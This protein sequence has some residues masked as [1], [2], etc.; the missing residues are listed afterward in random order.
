MLSNDELLALCWQEGD[1]RGSLK[2]LV[3]QV[4][5]PSHANQSM[6]PP[7][8][9]SNPTPLLG[10]HE[11]GTVPAP[12][13]HSKSGSFSS[14]SSMGDAQN[15]GDSAHTGDS[16]SEASGRMGILHRTKATSRRANGASST[17]SNDDNRSPI[18][19]TRSPSQPTTPLL[20]SVLESETGEKD[21][22][23]KR[24]I[25]PERSDKRQSPLDSPIEE[26]DESTLRSSDVRRSGQAGMRPSSSHTALRT[27]LHSQHESEP[28]Q[29]SSQGSSAAFSSPTMSKTDLPE[30]RSS[31]KMTHQQSSTTAEERGNGIS[32][33]PK[34]LQPGGRDPRGIDAAD[35]AHMYLGGASSPLEGSAYNVHSP[36]N[37]REGGTQSQ[38]QQQQQAQAIH[39][40][41]SI[42]DMAR[43]SRAAMQSSMQEM[44]ALNREQPGQ[45][46]ATASA[47]SIIRQGSADANTGHRPQHPYGQHDPRDPRFSPTTGMVARPRTSTGSER[48]RAVSYAESPYQHSMHMMGR[49]ASSHANGVDA[50]RNVRPGMMASP[51]MARPMT[52]VSLRPLHQDHRSYGPAGQAN[53]R[54][55]HYMNEFGA[56]VPMSQPQGPH[57]HMQQQGFHPSDPRLISPPFAPPRPLTLHD[58]QRF[59]PLPPG[60]IRPLSQQHR[61]DPFINSQFPASNAR[62]VSEFQ[63]NPNSALQ[64]GMT[65][66]ETMTRQRQLVQAHSAQQLRGVDPRET[67][68]MSARPM[69]P[70]HPSPYQG[71][72]SAP[73]TRPPVQL[74]QIHYQ[75]HHHNQPTP[76][77][78]R[79][80]RQQPPPQSR[81]SNSKNPPNATPLTRP[82]TAALDQWEVP[83]N[84]RSSGSSFAT[85]SSSHKRNLSSEDRHSAGWI[86]EPYSA[87]TSARTSRSESMEKE[88]ESRLQVVNASESQASSPVTQSELPYSNYGAQEIQRRRSMP[89]EDD[90]SNLRPLPKLPPLSTAGVKADGAKSASATEG[91]KEDESNTIR[92]SEWKQMMIS[93][94]AEGENEDSGT[95][96]ASDFDKSKQSATSETK[97]LNAI[98]PPSAQA[99]T[100]I[101]GAEDGG[102]FA[103]FASFDDEEDYDEGG[104]WAQPL[105]K[106][107]AQ[108]KAESQTPVDNGAI[109]MRPSASL[110]A[111]PRS[112]NSPHSPRALAG[113]PRRPILTLSINPSVHGSP[114]QVEAVSPK[115]LSTKIDNHLRPVPARES[116]QTKSILAMPSPAST[117]IHRRTSFARREVDWA[118]RP[119]PEQLY[120]NLDAF[121]PK[122]DLDK[123]VLDN[124]A[125]GSPPALSPK[126]EMRTS[127]PAPLS[128]NRARF[129]HKKSI[130]IVAQDRKKFL[131][132]ADAS[133]RR[134]V[135]DEG[136]NRRR[137]TK[138]WGTTV[139]EV[140]PGSASSASGVDS[141]STEAGARPVFKWV[142]GDLIGKGTYGRVYLALNATTGEMIAVKQ[143]ELPMTDSDREDAR[144]K[145]VVSALKSE[146]ETLKDLDHPNIVSY[147]GFE[148]TTRYLSIFLEYVPGGSVGSCLRKH[149]KLDEATIKSF[150]QQILVGLNYLHKRGILHRDLKADNLLVDF[151]GIVK[152]SDFGTVRKSEDIYGNIASMSIQGSIFWM[153][154]EVVSLSR[155]G[156]SAKVDIWSLGCVVLEMF[157]GRRPW[158]DEE[159]VQAMFK[160]G[161]ERKPPPIPPDAI[162]SRPATHFLK[163]CFAVDPASRPTAQ[164]LLEHVFPHTEPN[165]SFSES[166]LYKAL[167]R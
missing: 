151:N 73:P 28:G 145:G 164:R 79:P 38:Q 5:P 67:R 17:A 163:V 93:L 70:P 11:N 9:Y 113:S 126:T 137:S 39:N 144:Q 108:S 53:F 112:P 40:A 124:A 7:P 21:S 69:Y 25:R 76:D 119:P 13:L 139:V 57:P 10:L 128:S 46:P 120:D 52:P 167:H 125:P 103:S 100:S 105:D 43:R 58:H 152:I 14:R 35:A 44:P 84:E 147:L 49:P 66:Q 159:A 74:Q 78:H 138:L 101:A 51:P 153:A 27:S 117:D 34:S 75:Q 131:E 62:T 85:V 156:Y 15:Q 65:V 4:S 83:P 133:E 99:N 157:A 86:E 87:P 71:P 140:T 135:E 6:L 47:S 98:V 89:E 148:E 130:R 94:E 106:L 104:T 68:S 50:G 41:R 60:Y 45:R 166:S 111:G 115:N 88:K 110:I 64:P 116:P 127:S 63:R 143:V 80:V 123:P 31:D 149:G 150:L 141:P 16:G 155:A 30:R 26:L 162:L 114:S 77:N 56:R 37:A 1:E 142:K 82:H 95:A 102:T 90:L 134:K 107:P 146:I 129:T 2:F 59:R 48:E 32:Q 33:L 22:T 122:H 23:A 121:F 55:V 29:R 165:W 161:A 20:A 42:D 158:S 154:P 19:S 24:P 160:I 81:P 92:A 61:E 12:A 91:R 3:H 97:A 118:F 109:T 8:R 96:R 18:V 136:L 36:A 132:R 72:V 54:P